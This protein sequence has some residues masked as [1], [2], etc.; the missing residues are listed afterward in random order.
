M[1]KSASD[2]QV[3]LCWIERVGDVFFVSNTGSN[4]ISSFRLGAGS[5]PTLLSAVAAAP[6]P[7][8]IDLASSGGFLYAETGSTG[9]VDEF[10]VGP[11]G[12]L[13]PLGSVGGLPPG[14]EGIAAT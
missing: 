5:Q 1:T 9:T 14:I 3:A 4:T 10:A 6:N 11:N 2:G 7:G 13:V 12:T 8:P